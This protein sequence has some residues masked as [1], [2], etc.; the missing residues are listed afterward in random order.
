MYIYI[1]IILNI[2]PLE[3]RLSSILA[4]QNFKNNTKNQFSD[5]KIYVTAKFWKI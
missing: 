4:N 1:H 5:N 3:F 2:R